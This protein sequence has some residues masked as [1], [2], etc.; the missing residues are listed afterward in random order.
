MTSQLIATILI[1]QSNVPILAS[2]SNIIVIY[3]I[4]LSVVVD[5]NA[6]KYFHL[7]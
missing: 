4:N 3:S 6:L 7:V 5:N 2:Y 1:L